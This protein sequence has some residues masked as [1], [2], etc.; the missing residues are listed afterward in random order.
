MMKKMLLTLLGALTVSAV[1]TVTAFAGIGEWRQNDYGYWWQRTDGS[2]PANTWKW[3]DGNGDGI[4]ECYHFDRSGYMDSDTWVD[5][6]YVGNSGADGV[7][8]QLLHVL[9]GTDLADDYAAGRFD[10][11]DRE[12]YFDA[13]C[14]CLEHLPPRV[15]IHRMTGDGAKADLIAPRW[16][17]DKKR[18]W[19]ALQA[20][21]RLRD[22]CQGSALI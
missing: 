8:L 5:G 12:A 6:Y 21:L 9:R 7:K 10:V 15:T 2:Y 11:M 20:H 1:M 14:L 3:I 18:V 22:V 16:S 19:N 13:V 17:A 4:A